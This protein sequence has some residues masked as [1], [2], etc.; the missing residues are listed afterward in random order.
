MKFSLTQK[1]LF[2][3]P[4]DL[5]VVFSFDVHNLDAENRKRIEEIIHSE[6]F[7]DKVG[8]TLLLRTEDRKFLVVGLG[9]V[10]ELNM[11]DW[12]TAFAGVCRKAKEVRATT[13]TISLPMKEINKRSHVSPQNLVKGAVEGLELGAYAFTKH[14]KKEPVSEIDSVMFIVEPRYENEVKK[15]ITLGEITSKATSMARDLV[16]EPSSVTTPTFLSLI[17]QSLAK[18]HPEITCEVMGEKE[19]KK[20]GMGGLI[21]ISKGSDEEPKFIVLS[22]K[23]KG[24][25]TVVVVGKGV[26]FD[27]GGLSLKPDKSMETM[28]LDMAGAASVLGIFSALPKLKPSVN[29]IGLL[30]LCENMPSGSAVKPGDILTSY[31]GKT[32]EIIS[33]DAEGRVILA[34]ALSYAQKFHPDVIIDLATLTGACSIAL[35][36]EIAGLFANEKILADQLL[37][38]GKETGERLWELPLAREYEE[39]LKSPVA[40]IKNVAKT[41]A[42]GAITGALFLKPFVPENVQWAHIDIGGTAWQEKDTSLCPEGGTGFGVRLISEYLLQFSRNA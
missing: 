18:E 1:F 14:K 23:G 8:S 12:Q 40:D 22:Y 9:K 30:P 37:S 2:S 3:V 15:G 25:K 5:S 38:V 10:E 6:Q 33:T 13:V 32:I 27:S 34:D 39:L 28:K 29:V 21:G 19:I 41:R 35:G 17:A 11:F 4:A 7:E 16:N 36:E 31:N 24:E 20:L 42:G 26:T